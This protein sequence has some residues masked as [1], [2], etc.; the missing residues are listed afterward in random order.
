MS[1]ISPSFFDDFHSLGNMTVKRKTYDNKSCRVVAPA[2]QSLH[3]RDILVIV[4]CL[5]V[6]VFVVINLVIRVIFV[7]VIII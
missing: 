4:I 5:V 3:M 6:M 2:T 7:V 1:V